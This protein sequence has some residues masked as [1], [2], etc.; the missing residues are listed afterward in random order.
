MSNIKIIKWNK[1]II[2]NNNEIINERNDD[3]KI[4]MNNKFNYKKQSNDNYKFIYH[5][6]TL[7]Y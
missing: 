4:L 6:K 5:N 7:V 1:K 2:K 3:L